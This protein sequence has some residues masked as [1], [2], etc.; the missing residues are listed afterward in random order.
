MRESLVR[1]IGPLLSHKDNAVS[2]ILAFFF[3]IARYYRSQYPTVWTIEVIYLI[4]KYSGKT[5]VQFY[6]FFFA[7]IQS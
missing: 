6:Y 5:I 3:T 4:L 1:S 2:A 7:N